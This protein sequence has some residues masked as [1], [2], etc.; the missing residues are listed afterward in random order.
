M[1]EITMGLRESSEGAE[2]PI[3]AP[4]GRVHS[5]LKLISGRKTD[6]S[7]TYEDPEKPKKHILLYLLMRTVTHSRLCSMQTKGCQACHNDK[8]NL[9]QGSVSCRFITLE[10]GAG[11]RPNSL[12]APLYALLAD[13]KCYRQLTV[14]FQF[15]H[16][17]G[18][19]NMHGGKIS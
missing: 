13:R 10:D 6:I 18:N 19:K 9:N 5:L 15:W 7:S 11:H 17:T 4:A 3:R 2:A 8:L 16:T 1:R 14:T 12:N